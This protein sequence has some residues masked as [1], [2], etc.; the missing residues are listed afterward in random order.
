MFKLFKLGKERRNYINNLETQL[1]VLRKEV[2][3]LEATVKK[4]QLSAYINQ[5]NEQERKVRDSQETQQK[6]RPKKKS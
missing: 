3:Y 2:E 4:M 6:P 1:L 5:A